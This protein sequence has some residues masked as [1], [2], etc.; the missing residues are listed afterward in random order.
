MSVLIVAS[1][2]AVAVVV[3]VVAHHPY[4]I[5]VNF[6]TSR[7]EP[8]SSLSSYPVAP[9]PVTLSPPLS[10][11]RQLHHHHRC[12]HHLCS[13]QSSSSSLP[14]TPSPIAQ[15]SLSLLLLPVAIVVVIVSCHHCLRIN[16][17]TPHFSLGISMLV[18]GSPNQNGDPRTVLG[19]RIE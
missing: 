3:V 16:T 14:V 6:V 18:W 7:A 10:T 19:M 17:G 13:S 11:S 15:S 9:S 2:C 5:I 1:L 12:C 4:A 8:S